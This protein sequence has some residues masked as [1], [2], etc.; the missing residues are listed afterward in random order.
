MKSGSAAQGFTVF[1]GKGNDFI[2]VIVGDGQIKP[3]GTQPNASNGVSITA[4][5]VEI[6]EPFKRDAKVRPEVRQFSGQIE[7][8]LVRGIKRAVEH[9]GRTDA[10]VV[11]V[12]RGQGC[13]HQCRQVARI[14][15]CICSADFAEAEVQNGRIDQWVGDI[16]LGHVVARD[17]DLAGCCPYEEDGGKEK[18]EVSHGICL[19]RKY[20]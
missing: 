3:H 20:G 12:D 16:R 19:P 1:K 7:I 11:D 14:P 13:I 10:R 8:T 9:Q 4:G 18:D 5:L 15:C 6:I 17:G 2:D